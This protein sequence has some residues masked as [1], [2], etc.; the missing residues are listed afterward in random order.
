MAPSATPAIALTADVLTRTAPRQTN[1]SLAL[2]VF[3]GLSLAAVDAIRVDCR[4]TNG[5]EK[6]DLGA[7]IADDLGL[8]IR[9][10][11]GR[12]RQCTLIATGFRLSLPTW[13]VD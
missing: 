8:P 6:N 9:V 1:L 4:T 2:L 3:L 11:P 13:P 10:V 12:E 5:Y 7:F